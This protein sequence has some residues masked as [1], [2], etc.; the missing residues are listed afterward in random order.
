MMH[1][2]ELYGGYVQHSS[3]TRS[4]HRT[5]LFLCIRAVVGS[6]EY[7]DVNPLLP[8]SASGKIV[9]RCFMIVSLFR[10]SRYE[11]LYNRVKRKP[12]NAC[13]SRCPFVNLDAKSMRLTEVWRTVSFPERYRSAAGSGLDQGGGDE[14]VDRRAAGFP[15]T[16]SVNRE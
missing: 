15:T 16:T 4:E 1:A 5:S 3:K 9:I 14:G 11:R 8:T 12:I 2:P 6:L 10:H 13:F 7:T